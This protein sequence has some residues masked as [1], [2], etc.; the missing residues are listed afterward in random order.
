MTE[1][2]RA[3]TTAVRRAA[4]ATLARRFEFRI[5]MTDDELWARIVAHPQVRASEDPAPEPA[6]P[7]GPAFLAARD[8]AGRLLLRHWA[9]P[10][11]A[12]SPL[13]VLELERCAAHEIVRGRVTQPRQSQRI[14]LRAPG[15]PP[16][17]QFALPI[18]VLV[19][20]VAFAA[21]ALGSI[22]LWALPLLLV[23]F[24]VP[25][26]LVMLPALAMWNAESR[27]E[28]E[29]ELRR[30]IGELMVPIAL[31]PADDEDED[32][33]RQTRNQTRS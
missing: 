30:L 20:V 19:A 7:H 4:D 14:G 31:P 15:R 9:G 1:S 22:V 12:A 27:R 28:Q 2:T 6:P 8:G 5:A 23:L 25:S 24:A 17:W 32:P 29:L 21:Q 26:G 18:A 10:A 13:V 11:D 3:P 16:L 33:F